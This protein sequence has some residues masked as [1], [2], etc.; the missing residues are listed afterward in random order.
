[1]AVAFSV[2]VAATA[3]VIGGIAYV[4]AGQQVADEID[5]FLA[6][7]ANEIAEGQ[8]PAPR[9]GPNRRANDRQAVGLSVD[10]DSDVQLIDDNG[11]IVV[12]TGAV[13]P[14]DAGDRRIADQPRPSR[15]RTIDVDGADYRMITT[16]IQGGGA[17]QVARQLDEAN[18]LLDGLRSRMVLIASGM[19]VVAAIVGW[20]VARRTTRPLRALTA[21][22]DSVAETGSFS[23]PVD[24]G[25]NDEVGRLASGFER[26]LNALDLSRDQQHRLVQ[27][28]AHELRTPLTSIQANIDWLTRATELD[29][30]TREE[31][32]RAV[33]RELDE[34]NGVINEIIE[35]ATDQHGLPEFHPIDLGDVASAAVASFTGR[36]DR[37]VNL[38]I[39]PTM[40][41]GDADALQRAIANLLS[42]ADKFSPPGAPITVEVIDGSVAVGDS[43]P[44]IAPIDRSRVFD[45]FYRSDD[46]RATAGSGLGL[47]IVRGIVEAHGGKVRVGDAPSG[48]ALVGFTL[49]PSPVNRD[50]PNP[51]IPVVGSSRVRGRGRGS[52]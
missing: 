15:I 7:R 28:A 23:V 48:G 36:S 11:E 33:R 25:G 44:G 27:D 40:V 16:H 52:A 13:L 21:A 45:R 22:V 51:A 18:S 39:E 38:A 6:N 41:T 42:N 10:P 24:V 35:L 5:G 1:M 14:V 30:G 4:S 31:T 43:G 2:L 12:S 46:A 47:A 37:P 8:R 49:P 34:L 17:V 29:A 50:E 9:N 26:M 32:L 20:A 19:A 3:I